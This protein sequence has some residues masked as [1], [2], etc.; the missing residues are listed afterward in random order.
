MLRLAGHWFKQLGC[1]LG[2][3][4]LLFDTSSSGKMF[5]VSAK[6]RPVFVRL[7]G[8]LVGKYCGVGRALRRVGR[9]EDGESTSSDVPV[10]AVLHH[11]DDIQGLRAVAVLLV[12][13]DHAGVSFLSGGYVGVDVFFVLSGFLI[14]SILLAAPS[15]AGTCRSSTS[16][17]AGPGA[18]C[19]PRR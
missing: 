17:R 9:N 2:P 8:V 14:T 16:T 15:S 4:L 11:R 1:G 12:V 19:R 18:S 6:G 5:S 10:V 13:L 7:G 3:V